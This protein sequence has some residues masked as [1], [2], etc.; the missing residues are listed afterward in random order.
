L[1]KGVS[2]RDDVEV[3]GRAIVLVVVGASQEF[4]VVHVPKIRNLNG[5][6]GIKGIRDPMFTVV[7]STPCYHFVSYVVTM[8]SLCMIGLYWRR[9]SSCIIPGVWGSVSLDVRSISCVVGDVASGIGWSVCRSISCRVGWSISCNVGS[10]IDR[11][12]YFVFTS[13][14]FIH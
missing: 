12:Q 6:V 5:V 3:I 8:D 2:C 10:G 11:L 4:L 7:V 13:S 1:L 9:L 14:L